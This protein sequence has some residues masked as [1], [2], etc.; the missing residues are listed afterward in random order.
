MLPFTENKCFSTYENA[1]QEIDDVVTYIL[2]RLRVENSS[3]NLL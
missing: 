2:P 1:H 3:L